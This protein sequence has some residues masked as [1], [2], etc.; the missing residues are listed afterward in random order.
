MAINLQE[1]LK[2]LC[3]IEVAALAALS[4]AVTADAKPYM[5]HSQ[6]AF[7]YFTHRVGNIAVESDSHDLDVYEVELVA[8][9]VV[10][11]ITEGY[12]GQPESNLY[13]YLPA[14]I[15]T[16]NARELLQSDT[17]T[18]ALLGLVEARV[19]S[20]T[21]LRVFQMAGIQAQ[22]VG[23]EITVVCTFD[24]DITQQYL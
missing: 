5:I 22:Q 10:G 6:E 13:T 17:Y 16:I 18:T 2:R 23:T 14:L 20:S 15:A 1:A 11:H 19:S 4:P 21:G 12:H 9:L 24:D 8:R 3:A 7:P